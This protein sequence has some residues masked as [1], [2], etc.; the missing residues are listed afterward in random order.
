MNYCVPV[1]PQ[2]ATAVAVRTFRMLKVHK[3]GKNQPPKP[4][5]GVI[6]VYTQQVALYTVKNGPP[7]AEDIFGGNNFVDFGGSF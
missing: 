6:K 2:F 4:P 7:F 1:Q 3:M 5:K